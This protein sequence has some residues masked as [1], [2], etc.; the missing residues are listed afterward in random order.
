MTNGTASTLILHPEGQEAIVF[1]LSSI[2]PSADV[3]FLVDLGR[4]DFHEEDR[5]AWAYDQSGDGVRSRRVYDNLA[6]VTFPVIIKAVSSSARRRAYKTLA[7]GIVNAQGG[8]L[9]YKPE[10]AGESA[11]STFYHYAPSPPPSL[12][13]YPGNRWDSG[14]TSDGYFTLLVYVEL[15]THMLATS[16]PDAP[17][18]LV[19][20]TVLD[21]WVGDGLSSQVDIDAESIVGSW[22]ALTR[23]KVTPMSGYLDHL[24][25]SS[26]SSKDGDLASLVLFYEAEDAAPIAPSVAWRDIEDPG[27]SGGSYKRCL[28]NTDANGEPQGLRFTLTNPHVLQGRFAVFGVCYDDDEVVENWTHQ[29]HLTVGTAVQEGDN[30]YSTSSLHAWQLLYAGEFDIPAGHLTPPAEGGYEEGPTVDWYAT[31]A[32]GASEFRIDGIVLV[33]TSGKH[34][35]DRGTALDVKVASNGIGS[36][37][38]LYLDNLPSMQGSTPVRSYLL[39]TGG[40][41]KRDLVRAPRG[42]Y[43]ELA[44]DA[45]HTII[46]LRERPVYTVI[47]D[48]FSSYKANFWLAL[49]D[50]D[51]QGDWFHSSLDDENYIEGGRALKMY[52]G[53]SL[54]MMH[55]SL[56]DFEIEGRF[57]DDDFV[58]LRF[59]IHPDPDVLSLF[60]DFWA[61]DTYNGFYYEQTYPGNTVGWQTLV[62]KKSDM[63]QAGNPDWS[64][65]RLVELYPL[66]E[67][68]V[69]F[70]YMTIEKADP[71]DANSPNVTGTAWDFQPANGQW[72]I[73]E[74]DDEP[75]GNAGATLA[76]LDTS[77]HRTG[78]ALIS[79]SHPTDL[80]MRA[81][82]MAKRHPGQ[83]GIR[84]R[85]ET[86]LSSGY[87]QGYALEMDAGSGD[88]AVCEYTSGQRSVLES[89]TPSFALTTN[90]WYTMGAV[91][92]GSRHR[93]Y[94]ALSSALSYDDTALFAPAHLQAALTDTSHASGRCGV[95]SRG[96][97]GR[98]DQ[99]VVTSLEDRFLPGDQVTV[100]IDAVFRTLHPF[101]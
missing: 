45:D 50:F 80:Q 20:A 86:V 34:L 8:T 92:K 85:A 48:D 24:I 70:D 17:Q 83:A 58:I 22:P 69:T 57:T 71:G 2:N 59:Y 33:H 73:T 40:Q 9:E 19:P 29:V 66:G 88:L 43:L 77:S 62:I 32:S 52:G 81:R 51:S 26:R 7:E 99:C 97:L 25:Q 95:L 78:T 28:P 54:A 61:P 90:R 10:G 46:F 12:E 63:L 13:D 5:V 89:V 93:V 1:S 27:R 16:N 15:Q 53:M 18:E 56:Y 6:L 79:A 91:V 37:T 74:E 101:E 75:L 23:V 39:T 47:N 31:R 72:T 35:S 4:L 41:F 44:P 14:P 96:T 87:E 55:G 98:F 11:L 68:W 38:T 21:N 3:T 82:V 76:C 84:W 64:N 49:S 100:S 30:R 65:V 36:D 60:F 94:C 42:E 67:L